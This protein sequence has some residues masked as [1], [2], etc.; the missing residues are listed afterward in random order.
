VRC[1]VTGASGFIG[2]HLVQALAARGEAV[3]ALVRRPPEPA[4]PSGVPISGLD[5]ARALEGA[6]AV[7][8]LAARVHVLRDDAADPLAE[9]RRVNTELTLRLARVAAEV[10]AHFVFTSSIA[11]YGL[12]SSPEPLTEAT[13]AAPATPYGRSKLE[14]EEG[15]GR[16]EA[17]AGLKFTVLRP[18]LVYGPGNPGNM[19][20]LIR[21]V[22]SGLPLPLASLHNRRSLL[23][24]GNLVDALLRCAGN[25]A[26]QGATYLV[27]DSRELSTPELV[28]EI[29]GALK[30]PARLLPFP[31]AVLGGAARLLGHGA[32]FERLAGSLILD[33]SKIRREL[34][35]TPPVSVEEGLR[36]TAQAFL[37]AAP[38][39]PRSM[40]SRL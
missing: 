28:R 20:R 16:L 26:A 15:L 11:V 33:C 35:W 9:H 25:P 39:S 4:L 8:H 19:A 37:S 36:L 10:S 7:F 6:E 1:V 21:L 38:R 12:G 13:P 18:P 14:A 2:R 31:P 32:D 29:A 30:R 27:A 22:G 34:G 23:Y 40:V 24:V 17:E 3:T 5:D